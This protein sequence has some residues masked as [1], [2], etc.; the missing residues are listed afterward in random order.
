MDGQH[1][2][3]HK[4]MSEMDSFSSIKLHDTLWPEKKVGD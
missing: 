2:E 3:K 4:L 1:G